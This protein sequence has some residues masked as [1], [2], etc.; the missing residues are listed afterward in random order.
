MG[1]S[2]SKNKRLQITNYEKVDIPNESVLLKIATYNIDLKNTI[3]LSNNIKNIL[4]YI[5]EPYKGKHH[6]I[7]CLQGISDY[8]SASHLIKEL[9]HYT[10]SQGQILY[11]APNF[12]EIQSVT[13]DTNGM[14]QTIDETLK[15]KKFGQK[16]D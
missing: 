4:T 9:K 11:F 7:I 2:I 13:N 8:I 3:N 14:D 6:D 12:S 15:L 10:K 1:S 16:S 5:I